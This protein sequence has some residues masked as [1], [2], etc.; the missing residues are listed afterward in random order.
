LALAGMATTIGVTFTIDVYTLVQQRAWLRVFEAAEMLTAV[1]ILLGIPLALIAGIG[2]FVPE[3]RP[4]M[5]SFWRSRPI[6]AEQ[7]FASK[8]LIGGA[9][10]VLGLQ[11]PVC[12]LRISAGLPVMG[13]IITASGV[14]LLAF[15]I[16]AAIGCLVRH[17]IYAGILSLGVVV[18]I[19]L[20]SDD[21][22]WLS[23]A[24]RALTTG[25]ATSLTAYW[26]C[27]AAIVGA[28]ALAAAVAW[29]SVKFDWGRS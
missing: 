5:W 14:H 4:K 6:T 3:L 23:E 15:A 21:V 16:A 25:R 9:M 26:P 8:F 17:E 11:L 22:P 7:W 2:T 18:A 28:S 12:W 24:F 29:L 19:G 13:Y 27:L 1:T 10:L 20:A